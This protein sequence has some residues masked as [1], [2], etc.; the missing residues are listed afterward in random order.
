M[1]EVNQEINQ[2][3]INIIVEKLAVEPSSVTLD[4]NLSTDLG[5]DSLDVVEL[6]LEFE[7]VFNITIPEDQAEHIKTVGQVVAFLETKVAKPK[8]KA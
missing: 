8:A 2:K 5:A 3:V 7:R 6:I 4:A 1:P